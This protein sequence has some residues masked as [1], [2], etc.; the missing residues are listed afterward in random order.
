MRELFEHFRETLNSQS[1][2]MPV[3]IISGVVVIIFGFIWLPLGLIGLLGLVWLVYVTRYPDDI[4]PP[5]AEERDILAPM[6]GLVTLIDVNSTKKRIRI[7][8]QIHTNKLI[9]M[10]C[11]G[12]IEINM[13]I[14][15]LFLPSKISNASSLN[16]RREITINHKVNLVSSNIDSDVS[17]ILWGSPFARYLASPILEGR[18]LKTGIPIAIS[19]LHGEIDVLLPLDY[20]LQVTLGDFCIAGKTILAKSY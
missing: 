3:R 20:E 11:N 8:Q 7:S 6:D 14:D 15:G 13:F 2:G 9:L 18:K 19:L 10:P 5:Q 16:A 12:K 17:L 4:Y 1:P